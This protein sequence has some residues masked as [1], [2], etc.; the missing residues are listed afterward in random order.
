VD[1]EVVLVGLDGTIQVVDLGVGR[2]NA[3]RKRVLDDMLVRGFL[4]M[5]LH[6][7]VRSRR[8]RDLLAD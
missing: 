7:Q 1:E 2:E 6:E 5:R 4:L 3:W 8:F